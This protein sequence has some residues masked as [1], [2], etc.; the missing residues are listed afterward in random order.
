MDLEPALKFAALRVG[1]SFHRF[2]ASRG[3]ERESYRVFMAVTPLW[4]VISVEFV[5]SHFH[6]KEEFATYDQI[7]DFLVSDLR[8]FPRLYSS[9]GLTLRPLEGYGFFG[10]RRWGEGTVEVDDSLLNPGVE[11]FRFSFQ[12][13]SFPRVTSP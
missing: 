8:D 12:T 11:D 4:G 2:A 10:D 6:E 3:W 5:S 1:E 13:P 9:I 7:M